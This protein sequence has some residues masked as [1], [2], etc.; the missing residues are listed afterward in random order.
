M[1]KRSIYTFYLIGLLLWLQ[2]CDDRKSERS[3]S[4]FAVKS[5][6]DSI[7]IDTAS[8]LYDPVSKI[9]KWEYSP[10]GFKVLTNDNQFLIF[11]PQGNIKT[12]KRL[13]RGG[14]GTFPNGLA[15]AFWTIGD[16]D[17]FYF[18]G[19]NHLKGF[20]AE[21]D[22]IMHVDLAELHDDPLGMTYGG[23]T[24]TDSELLLTRW[25]QG[26]PHYELFVLNVDTQTL[27]KITNLKLDFSPTNFLNGR[28]GNKQLF[29][30]ENKGKK[31]HILDENGLLVEE[32]NISFDPEEYSDGADLIR[33]HFQQGLGEWGLITD[34]RFIE[35]SLYFLVNLN[36]RKKPEGIQDSRFL[37]ERHPD[38]Y[39]IRQFKG[40]EAIHLDNFGNY[41]TVKKDATGIH[42]VIKPLGK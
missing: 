6:T 41:K 1:G 33:Q 5:L 23:N 12:R 10:L 37:I 7:F 14:P 3:M 32:Q 25:R 34:A 28:Y 30:L 13:V 8:P 18:L 35:E 19:K 22:E 20:N 17:Y 9:H 36:P 21:L 16:N 31:L 15:T 40:I 26:T 29:V 27:K 4:D 38:Y 11:D 2:G 24:L 39:K 42:L